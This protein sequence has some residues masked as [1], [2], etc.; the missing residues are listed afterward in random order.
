ANF[1]AAHNTRYGHAAP[2]E[3]IQLANIRLTVTVA[4]GGADAA[5]WL[6]A[7]FSASDAQPEESRNVIFDDPGQP[8]AAR[9]LWR[10]GLAAGTEVDGPAV[11]EEPNS[12][13][14]LYPGDH[15]RISEHGH[16]IID[17]GQG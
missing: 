17:V 3:R 4:R 5:E 14:L 2:S 11:I 10:P 12:T 13:T 8:R 6:A 15:M 9:I 16:M 1:D 7:P